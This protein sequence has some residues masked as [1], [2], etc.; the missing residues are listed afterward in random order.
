RVVGGGDVDR[1]RRRD[2]AAAGAGDRGDVV[3]ARGLRGRLARGGG[4]R[5][6]GGGGVGAD[7]TRQRLVPWTAATWSPRGLYV[8]AWRGRELSAVAPNGRVAWTIAARGAVRDATWS[9]DGYR[10]AYRR[11][12]V[13]AVVAGDG[14]GARVLARPVR[15]VA[16]AGGPGGAHK[17][18]RGGAR[19]RGG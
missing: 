5:G 3:A 10:I 11:D 13:L 14:T 19:V 4:Q 17:L 12:D 15:A 1:A 8:A 2:A 7:G 18:A 9:P 16:P 6:G